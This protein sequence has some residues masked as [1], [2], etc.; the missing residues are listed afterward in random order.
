MSRVGIY[1]I[2]NKLN[3]KCYIGQ[4]QNIFKRWSVHGNKNKSN[5][6]DMA[7]AKA[8]TKYG[9]ENFT[10][11]ILELCN[12]NELND[13]EKY[14]VSKF[15]TYVKGYNSTTGGDSPE[16]SAFSKLKKD[17]IDV[18]HKQLL[19]NIIPIV[20]LAKM[21]GVSESTIRAVNTGDTWINS[22][23]DYPIRRGNQ[24]YLKINHI[25]H[26]C[27]RCNTQLVSK[28]KTGLCK[29]CYQAISK[30]VVK[31]SKYELIS[32][33]MKLPKTKIAKEY[34]VSDS[35]ICKWCKI[36][37]I[38]SNIRDYKKLKWSAGLESNQHMSNALTFAG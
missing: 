24:A 2:T 8:V 36:Y 13:K 10:F 29:V 25:I 32:K 19:D 9:I 17:T 33:V 28:T 7:I 38:P 12:K 34:N 6:C 35:L 4:S 11:E 30:K 22:E 23:L 5:N 15:D 1:K 21:Y 18:L 16:E 27:I 26:T 20:E 37:N 14:W 31:P 3:G